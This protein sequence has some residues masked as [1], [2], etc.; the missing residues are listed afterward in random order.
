[1]KQDM[2]ISYDILGKELALVVSRLQIA[3][4]TKN[5]QVQAY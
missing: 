3:A 5:G 2:L 4:N 1:V